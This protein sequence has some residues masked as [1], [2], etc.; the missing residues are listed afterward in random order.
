MT[1]TVSQPAKA[2]ILKPASQEQVTGQV[3][4]TRQTGASV[5]APAADLRWDFS[6]LT[7][8][9]LLH[10]PDMVLTAESGHTLGHLKSAAAAN[11][12]WL[13]LDSC[14]R[15]PLSL[16]QYLAEDWSLSW[17]SQTYGTLRDWV[18]ELTAVNDRGEPVRS[19][20]RV[21]KN[22][23]GYHLAPL[24]IGARHA[25][26]PVIEVSLRLIPS[27]TGLKLVRWSASNPDSLMDIWRQSTKAQRA[28]GNSNP[29]LALRLAGAGDHWR[30]EGLTQSSQDIVNSWNDAAAGT[31]PPT[32]EYCS[33]P[34][35]EAAPAGRPLFSAHCL[36]S[37]LRA[38]LAAAT[39]QHLPLVAY[40]GAGALIV[41]VG[42]GGESLQTQA[43]TAWGAVLAA[44]GGWVRPLPEASLPTGLPRRPDDN[45][46]L[47]AEVK[48]IL[49]PDGL[50]GP[51]PE[52]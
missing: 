7:A 11:G 44:E 26:G 17:L 12:L 22:V 25:L 50:F 2:N 39:E 5:G 24:Y 27:P 16:A 31:D 9:V 23:A 38:V 20:A 34:P 43:L 15:R 28:E 46:A 33:Q 51:L 19:G 8:K 14:H 21:V 18:M 35:D 45:A 6:A 49:D 4:Q 36:P 29:W 40:P 41:H 30:L 3:R 32:V 42:D 48:S 37:R 10:P 47:L 1:G 52:L 13:P